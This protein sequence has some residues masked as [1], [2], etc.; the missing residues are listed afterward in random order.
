MTTNPS[1][2]PSIEALRAASAAVPELR[3]RIIGFLSEVRGP[4]G[5]A[6][7]LD[8]QVPGT[9]FSLTDLDAQLVALMGVVDGLQGIDA[10]RLV[11][12]TYAAN[13]TQRLIELRDAVLTPLVQAVDTA[14]SGEIQALDAESWQITTSNGSPFNLA[15]SL[16]QLHSKLVEFADQVAPLVAFMQV[17]MQ[18]SAIVDNARHQTGEL[19]AAADRTARSAKLAEADAARSKGLVDDVGASRL[20]AERLKSEAESDRKSISGYAAEIV[21]KVAEIRQDSDKAEKLRVTVEAYQA[22]F[23]AF[24]AAFDEREK[25]YKSRDNEQTALGARLIANEAEVERLIAAA[26]AMLTGA[27]VAGLASAYAAARDKLSKELFWARWAFYIGIV[28]LVLSVLPLE[29]FILPHVFEAIGVTLPPPPTDAKL[30]ALQIAARLVL[31]VPAAWFLR[32]AANRHSALFRLR[33]EYAH[34]YALASSVEGFK[35]Q[36]EEFKEMIAAATYMHLTANPAGTLAD[37]AKGGDDKAPNPFLDKVMDLI[38]KK[39]DGKVS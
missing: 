15:P 8:R 16:Q 20:E 13:A 4:A 2:H 35:K 29:T 30:Y 22:Q 36:A 27:N 26:E 17:G 28:L 3:S 14:R 33:E 31:L 18:F 12:A 11:P 34:R 1:K 6:F 5:Q 38:T 37:H 19:F 24:K 10:T 39:V 32:F 23:D 21:T 7:L 25:S 9:P